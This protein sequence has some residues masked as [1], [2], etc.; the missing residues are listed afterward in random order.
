MR[1]MV[2]GDQTATRAA[3]GRLICVW[4]CISVAVIVSCGRTKLK[5]KPGQRDAAVV[6]R[7]PGAAVDSPRRPDAL[8]A[9]LAHVPGRAT[10][11]VGLGRPAALVRGAAR[12]WK[13][14]AQIPDLTAPMALV[15]Q[16][17]G[18]AV[19]GW[20]PP[21]TLWKD[22]GIDPGGGIVLV[23]VDSGANGRSGTLALAYTLT[24]QR[25]LK[26]LVGPL[27]VPVGATAQAKVQGIG[28]WWCGPVSVG[29]ACASSRALLKESA[30]LGAK[31]P[32]Q[33]LVARLPARHFGGSDLV[34]GWRS[35]SGKPM[36]MAMVR[37][38]SRGIGARLRLRGGELARW[39]GWLGTSRAVRPRPVGA[40]AALWLN[41]DTTRVA[42]LVGLLPANAIE[43]PGPGPLSPAALLKQCTGEAMLV[44]GPGTWHLRAVR[45][46]SPVGHGLGLRPRLRPGL[47]RPV[48]WTVS[49]W[50]VWARAPAGSLIIASAAVATRGPPVATG[51]GKKTRAW[52]GLVAGTASLAAQV[53]LMDPLELLSPAQRVRMVAALA[54]LPAGERAF[55][56]LARGLL[57]LLGEAEVLVE[58]TSDGALLRVSCV[59]AAGGSI[60]EQRVFG[61]LWRAKWQGGGFF[62]RQG[63]R[64]IA[65]R[66]GSK[67]LG[68]LARAVQG[69]RLAPFPSRWLTDSLL[70][71]L[72]SLSGPELSCAVLA[73]R[74]Q[75]CREPLARLRSPTRWREME[76]M[77]LP[78]HRRRMRRVLLA[79]ARREEQALG[80]HCDRL[81]GRLENG[82]KVRACL[83]ASDCSKFARCLVAAFTP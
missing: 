24:P 9:L 33:T 40:V 68:R 50:P 65:S 67:P 56:G 43:T 80:A 62:D 53:P 64:R 45:R 74:L 36:T 41:L 13:L 15:A 60:S 82:L 42:T 72:R 18:R 12:F 70:G 28:A 73:S 54:G 75:R 30:A 26:R 29:V 27:G 20:P 48:R 61:R 34:G 1:P 21:V 47:G 51:G 35:Q 5:V 81:A 52:R 16:R 6:T 63:L 22:L 46:A 78:A 58:K 55:V 17:V 71:L 32:S 3:G 23:G 14:L 8:A 79:R 19:G 69:M 31:P 66:F 37:F 49:G 83:G 10:W 11:F 77:I 7:T 25:L 44:V 59:S 38:R 4:F 39:L 2:N 57:T 76:T